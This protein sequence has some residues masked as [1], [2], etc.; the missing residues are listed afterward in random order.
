MRLTTRYRS[1]EFDQPPHGRG[2]AVPYPKEYVD[3]RLR[4]LCQLLEMVSTRLG[5]KALVLS[6]YRSPGFNARVL[7]REGSAHIEGWAADIWVPGRSS[8]TVF[9]SLYEMLLGGA[10]I[11]GLALFPS[12]VHVDLSPQRDL[13]PQPVLELP[14]ILSPRVAE[15]L[16]LICHRPFR[17]CQGQHAGGP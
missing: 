12:Y 10:R 15:T 14:L 16:C 8:E 1:R 9:E 7:G 6:G 4:P 5:D 17:L 11:G 3:D 13:I 2:E